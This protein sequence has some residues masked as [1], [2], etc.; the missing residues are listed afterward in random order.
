MKQQ[1]LR[2]RTRKTYCGH[3]RRFGRF[4]VASGTSAE[5][6]VSAYLSWLAANRSAATQKQALN[7]LVSLYRSL[8]KE[9]MILPEWT[10]PYVQ[11]RVLEWVTLEEALKIIE[12]LP[13]P[14][15]ALFRPST[16]NPP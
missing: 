1:R 3:V 8:G 12:L 5:E 14:W 2:P 15:D 11:Q 16:R 9:D 7:S 10:R 13:S 4:K 6:K